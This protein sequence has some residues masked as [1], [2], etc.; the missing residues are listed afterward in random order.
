ML[1]V[2]VL[3]GNVDRF[4]DKRIEKSGLYT[5]EGEQI[6]LSHPPDGKLPFSPH[7]DNVVAY[8]LVLLPST[9]AP[10]N[11][12]SLADVSRLGGILL[13]AKTNILHAD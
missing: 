1:V 6:L 13:T 2:Q 5:I 8:N 7:S 12:T 10:E 11:V 4:T 9:L 3:Y